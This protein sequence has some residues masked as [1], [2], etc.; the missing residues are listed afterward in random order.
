MRNK[1]VQHQP[2][3]ERTQNAFH[4]HQLHQASAQEHHSQHKDKLHHRI[5]IRTEKPPADTRHQKYNQS[6]QQDHLG[7]QQRPKQPAYLLTFIHTANNSQHHQGQ[8]HSHRRPPNSDT[9]R[10]LPGQP[11]T[12]D[13][14]ISYQSVAGIHTGQQHRGKKPITQHPHTAPYTQPHRNKESEHTKNQPLCPVLLEIIHIHLK[15]CQKH[16]VIESHF[17]EQLK[18][19]VAFQNIEAILSHYNP[20]K[21]HTNDVRDTQTPQNHGSEQDDDKYQEEYPSRIGDWKMYVKVE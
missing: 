13:N 1:A 8:H 4:P 10:P 21:Y 15:A 3:K 14:G 6:E 7:N 11:I 19:T 18:T 9:D 12:A 17:S 5:L 16:D 2:G 20:G